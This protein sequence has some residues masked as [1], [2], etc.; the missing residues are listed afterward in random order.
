MKYCSL[1]KMLPFWFVF[2]MIKT[3]TNLVKSFSCNSNN[4]HII[5]HRHIIYHLFLGGFTASGSRGVFKTLICATEIC[6]DLSY[7]TRQPS[8]C[9]T[10][11]IQTE[12]N[13]LVG[14]RVIHYIIATL[15]RLSTLREIPE[16][17]KK[18]DKILS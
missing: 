16:E 17:A 3:L 8:T 6:R 11:M 2:L 7:S 1:M 13:C 12:I 18:V 9:N 5:Y 10:G 14:K 15:K 4:N